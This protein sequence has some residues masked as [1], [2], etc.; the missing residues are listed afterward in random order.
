[1]PTQNASSYDTVLNGAILTLLNTNDGD[2]AGTGVTGIG[3]LERA[4][5]ARTTY[6]NA[7]RD[8]AKLRLT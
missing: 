3:A 4:N 6:I 8:A 1:M 5:T 2:P 7:E